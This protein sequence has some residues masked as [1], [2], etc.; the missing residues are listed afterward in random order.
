MGRKKLAKESRRL[1]SLRIGGIMS[2]QSCH[3]ES[4]GSRGHNFP[5]Q[6]LGFISAGIFWL[7]GIPKDKDNDLNKIGLWIGIDMNEMFSPFNLGH[8][9]GLGS[10]V[11]QNSFK[12]H[13]IQIRKGLPSGEESDPKM[14]SVLQP[15]VCLSWSQASCWGAGWIRRCRGTKKGKHSHFQLTGLQSA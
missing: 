15:S 4:L 10:E 8:Y 3:R 5:G 9:L 6:A 1:V 12:C 14:P 7:I 2:R 11:R 13:S